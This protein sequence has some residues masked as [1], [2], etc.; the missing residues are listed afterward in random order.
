MCMERK[1]ID[2]V[3]SNLDSF[4]IINAAS[5]M[6]MEKKTLRDIDAVLYER[7]GDLTDQ[8]IEDHELSEE[9]V[10]QNFLSAEDVFESILMTLEDDI[11]YELLEHSKYLTDEDV[12]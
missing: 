11:D 6:A 1:L 9:W 12:M 5:K 10:E 7:I 8:F 3:E 2:F 4:T